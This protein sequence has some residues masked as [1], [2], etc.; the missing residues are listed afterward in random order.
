MVTLRDLL[1]AIYG[2]L[3]LARLDPSGLA[4]F[5]NTE[6]SFW[7]SFWAAVV[8]APGYILILG[9]HLIRQPED[10]PFRYLAVQSIAYV[11]GWVAFP[12]AMVHISRLLDRED[13]LFRYIAAY[14]WFHLVRT[15]ILV[16]LA[17]LSATAV[18]EGAL[19]FLSLIVLA[20][21][22]MYDWFIA[23]RALEIDMMF[24]SGLVFIDLFLGFMIDGVARSLG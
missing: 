14:N 20:A 22:L 3:R 17:L 12:L 4:F 8:V 16:P 13:K 24:A 19:A 1:A 21:L 2:A 9:L 6:D 10:D 7:R 23:S 5:D 11:I 18:P 15:A